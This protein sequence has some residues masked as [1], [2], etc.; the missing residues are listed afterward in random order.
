MVKV[1]L[2]QTHTYGGKIYDVGEHEFDEKDSAQ[3]E[4]ADALRKS[5]ERQAEFRKN[6]H[7]ASVA[8][9]LVSPKGAVPP[10]APPLG[11]AVAQVKA[12]Q[13]KEA[14]ERAAAEKAHA[15]AKAMEERVAAEAD[16][17]KKR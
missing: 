14:A 13:E 5:E 15:D 6:P 8:S 16:K 2:T 10:V 7:R 11:D 1:N 12:Q 3:K 17:N 9:V 4:A